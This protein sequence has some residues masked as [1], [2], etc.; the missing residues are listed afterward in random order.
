MNEL[1][2]YL[3]KSPCSILT[4]LTNFYQEDSSGDRSTDNK[5]I[6]DRVSIDFTDKIYYIQPLQ[7]DTC[8]MMCKALSDMV[9]KQ[10]K[11]FV[12]KLY[13]LHAVLKAVSKPAYYD[14]YNEEASSA[15]IRNVIQRYFGSEGL[16]RLYLEERNIHVVPVNEAI[17]HERERVV[18][19]EMKAAIRSSLKEDVKLG[20]VTG[21]TIARLFQ[22]IQ[23]PLFSALEWYRYSF[24]R[25]YRDVNFNTLCEYANKMLL[26]KL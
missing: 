7:G 11:N 8:A 2:S 24:W 26:S 12:Q 19:A 22:G 5:H 3:K 23:S 10:E 6:L 21:R 17:T 14:C 15:E 25:R 16:D 1:A 18:K 4:E 13:V 20:I 9:D